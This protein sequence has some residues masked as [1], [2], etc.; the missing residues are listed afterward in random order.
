MNTHTPEQQ[1]DAY[2]LAFNAAEPETRDRLLQQS[3][4]A[5]VVF[6]NP[7]GLGDSRT[8]LSAHIADFHMKMPGMVFKTDKCLVTQGE[9]LTVWSMYTPDGKQV[10][11][12]YNFVRLDHD[13][14]FAYMAGFF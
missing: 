13:G 1:W 5:N 11:T 12:G 7:G 4:A 8:A 10:A 9:L 2:M 14:R 3:V 6:T